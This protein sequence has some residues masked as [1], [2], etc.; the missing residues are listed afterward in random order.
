MNNKKYANEVIEGNIQ[1]HLTTTL[2]DKFIKAGIKHRNVFP[3]LIIFFLFFFQVSLTVRIDAHAQQ[4][5][6]DE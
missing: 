5:Y 2:N 1:I 4:H 3:F 6:S